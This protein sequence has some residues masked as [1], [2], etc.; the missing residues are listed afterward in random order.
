[1]VALKASGA[2]VFFNFSNGKFTVQS[3]R[4]C[5]RAGLDAAGLPAGGLD[6]DRVDPEAGRR[7][8]ARSARSPSPTRRTR[9]TR[10]GATTPGIKDYYEFMKRWAPGLDAEDSLN[11]TAYSMASCSPTCCAAAATT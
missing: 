6:L 3:L 2:N 5:R 9:S 10:S 7:S 8:S 4:R 1:M 11:V